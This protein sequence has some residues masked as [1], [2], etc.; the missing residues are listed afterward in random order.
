MSTLSQ[1]FGSGGQK[2]GAI[3]DAPAGSKFSDA[4][5][6]AKGG[7]VLQSAYPKLFSAVGNGQRFINGQL[8]TGKFSGAD[9]GFNFTAIA[10]DGAGTWLA[11]ELNVGLFRSTDNGKTWNFVT[12]VDWVR[13]TTAPY[14]F[15]TCTVISI[16]YSQGQWALYGNFSYNA[17]KTAATGQVSYSTDGGASFMSAALPSG[18]AAYYANFSSAAVTAP[19]ALLT[20]TQVDAYIWRST[21][22]GRTWAK[23]YT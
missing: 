1:F 13:S 20:I 23:C 22:N 17:N 10:T 8:W 9:Q 11:A 3:F 21:D 18:A 6:L 19:N 12:N 4:L 2:I 15:T 7:F 14:Y 16:T 5:S